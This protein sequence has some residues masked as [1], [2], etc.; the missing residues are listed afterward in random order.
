MRRTGTEEMV[1]LGPG[2]VM[3]FIMLKQMAVTFA[4]MT[5]V[6]VPLFIF[7][8]SG[9]GVIDND[10]LGGFKLRLGGGSIALRVHSGPGCIHDPLSESSDDWSPGAVEALIRIEKPHFNSKSH[11]Y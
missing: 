10:D 6:A 3:Y 7:A 5:L 11:T 1:N 8:N 9:N 2:N 4:V